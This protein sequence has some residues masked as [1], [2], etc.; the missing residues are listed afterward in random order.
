MN[1][2]NLNL[3]WLR[4]DLIFKRP[5]GTSRGVLK[6]KTSFF[7]KIFYSSNSEIFGLGECSL[8]QGLSIDPFKLLPEKLDYLKS[9]TDDALKNY[10]EKF[11]DFPAL[12]F[13]IEMALID[14]ENGG[15]C[16]L[17]DN[18]FTSGKDKTPI[19]G[20]VWMG[21]YD[22][23]NAQIQ[24]KI[25]TGFDCIKLKIGAINFEEEISLIKKIR[26]EFSEEDIQIRVDANGAFKPE[27]ALE[28]L[29]RLADLKIHSIEQ[30]IKQ[31]QWAEMAK[32]CEITPLPI[33][34]DE[35]LIGVHL[36]EERSK[37]IATIKPQYI[38]LK[39]SLVGGIASS[40]EWIDI[41]EKNGIGFW[42]TSALESNVGLNA[43]AQW[44]YDIVQKKPSRK[45]YQ[46]L[47]TGKLFTNNID[48]PLEIVEGHL[49]YKNDI[50]WNLN[51]LD[52]E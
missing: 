9:D 31:K 50:S 17:F 7:I 28:K 2:N 36:F 38:I 16:C 8:I 25:K 12:V 20:L 26:A 40:E 37:M 48:S 49:L 39:P 23:M 32:L 4:H 33:A 5:S 46:G 44:T 18:D 27:T 47:G 24:E 19:N 22:F 51:V 43:I 45:M 41:A 21:D 29:Q 42:I 1:K 35:E 13:A 3:T 30:P 34:L 14:L 6:T 52:F 15:K 11:K 10:Q